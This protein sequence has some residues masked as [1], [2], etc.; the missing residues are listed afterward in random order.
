MSAVKAKLF[1]PSHK[2][3]GTLLS[4]S[5]LVDKCSIKINLIFYQPKRNTLFAIPKIQQNRFGNAYISIKQ[6]YS[7]MVKELSNYV[8]ISVPARVK[9]MLEK[10]KGKE[11]WGSFLLKLYVEARRL[12]SKRAFDELTRILTEEDL[13]AIA[14]SS[15]EFREGF[16]LR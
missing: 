14:E 2:L 13:R 11:D 9:K 12:K 7:Y 4:L 6:L 1:M 3:L 5:L 10:A 15:K 16:R 8:T